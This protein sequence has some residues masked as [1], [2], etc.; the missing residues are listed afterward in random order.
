MSAQ[1]EHRHDG[2]CPETVEHATY[3]GRHADLAAT[4]LAESVRLDV[5]AARVPNHPL[6]AYVGK[7]RGVTA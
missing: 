4:G 1:P 7:H 6:A 2:S 3:Q 5:L